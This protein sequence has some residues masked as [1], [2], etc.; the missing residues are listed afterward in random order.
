MKNPLTLEAAVQQLCDRAAA[1]VLVESTVAK[2]CEQRGCWLARWR[3]DQ[4]VE[5]A[6]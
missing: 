1:D 6:W 3:C 5:D 4:F 2:V